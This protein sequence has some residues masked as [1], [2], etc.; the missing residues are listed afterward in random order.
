LRKEIER[1]GMRSR[2]R[3][4]IRVGIG[5]EDCDQDIGIKI[6]DRYLGWDQD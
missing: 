6:K 2:P 3:K 4:K 1:G 5:I